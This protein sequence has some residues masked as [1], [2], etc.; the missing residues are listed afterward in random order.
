MFTITAVI[1]AK[2]GAEDVV[3]RALCAVLAAAEAN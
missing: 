1:R 3:E 2:A